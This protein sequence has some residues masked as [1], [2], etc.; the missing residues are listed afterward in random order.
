MKKL[1]AE[2]KVFFAVL[3]GL[4]TSVSELGQIVPAVATLKSE[5]ES[6]ISKAKVDVTRNLVLG[7]RATRDEN[8]K[9]WEQLSKSQD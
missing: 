6:L 1:Q 7:D 8:L 4:R 9:I 3:G 5:M 2:Q